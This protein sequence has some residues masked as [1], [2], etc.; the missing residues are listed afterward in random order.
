M[1][2]A[3]LLGVIAAAA[4]T[5]PLLAHAAQMLGL[6]RVAGVAVSLAAA[7]LAAGVWYWRARRAV[8]AARARRA[9]RAQGPAQRGPK[10]EERDASV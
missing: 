1:N 5:L 8:R 4:F 10:S 2:Y 3:A 6:P 7:L 9:A